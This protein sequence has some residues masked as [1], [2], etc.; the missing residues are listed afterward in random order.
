MQQSRCIE[1]ERESGTDLA[2]GRWVTVDTVG[3]IPPSA[4]AHSSLATLR[5]GPGPRYQR[6]DK[7]PW[8]NREKKI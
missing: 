3:W 1:R 5:W 4:H 2:S 7:F 8:L 6:R